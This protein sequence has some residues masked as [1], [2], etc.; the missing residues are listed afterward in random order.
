MKKFLAVTLI[1]ASIFV[2]GCGG[3]KFAGETPAILLKNSFWVADSKNMKYLADALARDDMEYLKQLMLEG[4]VFQVDRDTKVVRS[5]LAAN[6]HYSLISF[7]EGRYTNKSGCALNVAIYTEEEYQ[8]YL[9]EKRKEEERREQENKR[10]AQERQA[11]R[12]KER[13]EKIAQEQAK[14]DADKQEALALIQD[15]L[16]NSENYFIAITK[17][18]E[19]ELKQLA[20][21]LPENEKKLM[22][23]GTRVT[24][25]DSDI[26]ECMKHAREII[27]NRGVAVLVYLQFKSK[28]GEVEKYHQ[29]AEQLRQEFRDKYGY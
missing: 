10:R 20:I 19:A 18:N 1:L 8:N 16:S 5:G 27:K 12:E 11:Q 29:K 9:E 2:V 6:K 21:A 15:C 25:V 14:K 23:A 28:G 22:I 7:K 3:E 4:K 26:R 17:D 13:Q 24:R